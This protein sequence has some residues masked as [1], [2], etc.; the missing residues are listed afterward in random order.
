MYNPYTKKF[1][2]EYTGVP[3]ALDTETLSLEK[4]AL[5]TEICL[6]P[7]EAGDWLISEH[8]HPEKYGDKLQHFAQNPD[9][10]AW[11]D[12]VKGDYL[13][14]LSGYWK[15]SQQV[16]DE[17]WIKFC[18][19]QDYKIVPIL[20]MRGT[21]FDYPILM[22]FMKQ[23]GYDF[24]KVF[25]YRNTRDM[26]TLES[27]FHIPIAKGDHTAY[28]DAIALKAQV[29]WMANKHAHFGKEFRGYWHEPASSS[30]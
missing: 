7:I 15:T 29:N 13:F 20:Y 27:F 11:H 30:I 14:D 23:H 25:H 18:Q 17:I 5:I 16:A 9:T 8:L 2:P 10:L 3:I 26:R 28:G 24:S 1:V 6:V 12:K 21:D 22:H 4:N 19:M